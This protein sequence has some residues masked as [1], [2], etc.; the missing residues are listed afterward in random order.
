M[1]TARSESRLT[2]LFDLAAFIAVQ[3]TA[4]LLIS[5]AGADPVIV[6]SVFQLASAYLVWRTAAGRAGR[7]PAGGAEAASA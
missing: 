4:I 6:Q 7:R 5:S 3:V 2:W 1:M